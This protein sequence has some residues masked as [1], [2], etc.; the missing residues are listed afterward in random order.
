LQSPQKIEKIFKIILKIL[1]ILT[2]KKETNLKMSLETSLLDVF[3]LIQISLLM[4]ELNDYIKRNSDRSSRIVKSLK[5]LL[6]FSNSMLKM[7]LKFKKIKSFSKEVDSNPNK[8]NKEKDPITRY[9]EIKTQFNCCYKYLKIFKSHL[10]SHEKLIKLLQ[11]IKTEDENKNKLKN[12]K[13]HETFLK[14]YDKCMKH[15]NNHPY[16]LSFYKIYKATKK[17]YDI[18][19]AYYSEDDKII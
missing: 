13:K 5:I 11:E 4:D 16:T 9:S 12:P 1:E 2:D 7:K 8:D 17:I 10:G 15:M 3:L 19:S 18:I 6:R 14:A